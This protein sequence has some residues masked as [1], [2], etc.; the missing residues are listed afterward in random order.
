MSSANERAEHLILLTQRLSERLRIEIDLLEAHKPQELAGSV[1]D[2]RTLSSHYRQ[3]TLRLKNNP[4]LLADISAENKAALKAATET[5]MDIS[6]RHAQAVEAAKTISEGI[7]LAIAEDM[8]EKGRT[9]TGYGPAATPKTA[10]SHS[11]TGGYK[12]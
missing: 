4:S 10:K 8:G 3:E 7:L 1:E 12:A 5:F 9:A 2:T 6:A 11:L